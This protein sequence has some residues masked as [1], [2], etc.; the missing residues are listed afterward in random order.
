MDGVC[1]KAVMLNLFQLK[2]T[3]NDSIELKKTISTDQRHL[4]GK[5]LI[6][7][8]KDINSDENYIEDI[9][10][11]IQQNIQNVPDNFII[12]DANT[13]MTHRLSK[14][15]G[16]YNNLAKC[17]SYIITGS[18]DEWFVVL[19]A[20]MNFGT[21]FAKQFERVCKSRGFKDFYE[22]SIIYVEASNWHNAD[23]HIDLLVAS[24]LFNVHIYIFNEDDITNGRP[25]LEI[26]PLGLECSD[27]PQYAFHIH[28]TDTKDVY[29]PVIKFNRIFPINSHKQN[30]VQSRTDFTL[31][32][33]QML[34]STSNQD[35]LCLDSFSSDDK[36]NKT[37]TPDHLVEF[38]RR[39]LKHMINEYVN[40]CGEN[41]ADSFSLK[42]V[43][44]PKFSSRS[45]IFQTLS[46]NQDGNDFY[47][48]LSLFLF[49][50]D[51]HHNW[52]RQ[53]LFM[54]MT[55]LNRKQ[56]LDKI[57]WMI[58]LKPISSYVSKRGVQKTGVS[59]KNVEIQCAAEMFEVPIILFSSEI[60]EMPIIF[61]PN[62]TTVVDK[63]YGFILQ[64]D[65]G[66]F[67]PVIRFDKTLEHGLQMPYEPTFTT[68]T[69]SPEIQTSSLINQHESPFCSTSGIYTES[70]TATETG[71]ATET[72]PEINENYDAEPT[73]TFESDMLISTNSNATQIFEGVEK[74]SESTASETCDNFEC[75]LSSATCTSSFSNVDIEPEESPLAITED[76]EIVNYHRFLSKHSDT[77]SS[78][79]VT[80]SND[81]TKSKEANRKEMIDKLF[82][83][84]NRPD[85]YAVPQPVV[86]E[87]TILKLNKLVPIIS[88][89]NKRPE[90][91]DNIKVYKHVEDLLRFS[92]LYELISCHINHE[93]L[94]DFKGKMISIRTKLVPFKNQYT[95]ATGEGSLKLACLA[96]PKSFKDDCVAFYHEGNEKDCWIKIPI[97][98]NVSNVVDYFKPGRTTVTGQTVYV[99]SETAIIIVNLFDTS[100]VKWIPFS[101]KDKKGKLKLVQ[102]NTG[103]VYVL[104][105]SHQRI[106]LVKPDEIQPWTRLKEL[107]KHRLKMSSQLTMI[108]SENTEI[109]VVPSSSND[110]H[111]ILA[112]VYVEES[113]QIIPHRNEYVIHLHKKK[114][115]F[116]VSTPEICYSQIK[117]GS[118]DEDP[119]TR[120]LLI[121]ENCLNRFVAKLGTSTSVM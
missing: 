94:D 64:H 61:K 101:D 92:T 67:N 112:D 52:I 102:S 35:E 6:S 115:K 58:D 19:T 74:E 45:K 103:Q 120:Y 47:G 18:E 111:T 36:C 97:N 27:S 13:Y 16:M 66:Y 89:L 48:S 79:Q 29:Q 121:G 53:A 107:I 46:L 100:N 93:K 2:Q 80:V 38:E 24:S 82:K 54:F 116:I 98:P 59:A 1:P 63:N 30:I 73:R 90:L 44:L 49:G 104:D 42:E 56:V 77:N 21:K 12:D 20:M 87:D 51:E 70:E 84:L 11:S 55:D 117:L 62:E 99:L 39:K 118:Y 78:L 69:S 4:F 43:D 14:D 75:G 26:K 31:Q 22:Y 57:S 88:Y 40:N 32:S 5:K 28:K 7:Y 60:N 3:L 68:S 91:G 17:I 110:K 71:T 96:F 50:T 83:K 37:Q 114:K 106:R 8:G 23:E 65:D 81:Y 33:E 76:C 119:D 34:I 95:V 113:P 86:N 85:Q 109:V 9:K 72:E 15:K 41:T 25:P 108:T 105:K 10:N